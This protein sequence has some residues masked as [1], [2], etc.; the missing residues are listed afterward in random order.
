M[1]L[2]RLNPSFDPITIDESIKSDFQVAA[3]LVEAGVQPA[4]ERNANA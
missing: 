1:I 3:E 2:E 4:G